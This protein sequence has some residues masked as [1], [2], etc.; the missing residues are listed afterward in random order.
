MNLRLVERI[1]HPRPQYRLITA[2]LGNTGLNLARTQQ[3]DL[4][5]LDLNLPDMTGDEVLHRLKADPD[6]RH[7]PVIMVSADAMGERIQRRCLGALRPSRY[8]A[9]T[10]LDQACGAVDRRHG[11]P[12]RFRRR[13][14]PGAVCRFP[15]FGL[16]VVCGSR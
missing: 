3:P 8:E 16:V 1:L 5:L 4:I 9:S 7:I 2:T 6:V 11:F 10:N 14:R 13:H 12:T 15:L